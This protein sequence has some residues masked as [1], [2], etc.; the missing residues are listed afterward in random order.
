MR[1]IKRGEMS[2]S[3]S[4]RHINENNAIVSFAPRQM[5]T[6]YK[7][8]AD[9][10]TKASFKV[11]IK[12]CTIKGQTYHMKSH[13]I[14]YGQETFRVKHHG[15]THVQVDHIRVAILT[16]GSAHSI[17]EKFGQS[18]SKGQRGS[19]RTPGSGQIK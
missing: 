16:T 11:K 9:K 3:T 17:Q 2:F 12:A 18:N 15:M 7:N 1:M 8:M 14:Q 13:E 19:L 6:K 4:F 10:I 5:P